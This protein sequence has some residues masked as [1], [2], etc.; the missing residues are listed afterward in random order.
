VD[1]TD[2]LSLLV[3]LDSSGVVYWLD[4]GWGVDC[5]LGEETRPHGD[6]DLVVHRR[7]VA[8]ATALLRARGYEVVR[9]WMPTSLAFRNPAGGE[10]DLHPID[11]TDDGGGDQVLSDGTRWHYSAP[12]QGSIAGTAVRCA[13]AEEQLLMHQGYEP[14]EIDVEDVRRLAQRFRLALPEPFALRNR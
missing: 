3:V 11:P 10:V 4:G 9:D 7:Y 2:V 5:L 12:V 8:A 6:L 13:S 14:R 1:A